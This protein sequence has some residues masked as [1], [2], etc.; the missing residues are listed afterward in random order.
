MEG[1]ARADAD[2]MVGMVGLQS[3]VGDRGVV[4]DLWEVD[5]GGDVTELR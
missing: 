3:V 1:H 5:D 4:V 2:V